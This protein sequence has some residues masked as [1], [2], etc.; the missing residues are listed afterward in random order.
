MFS[1]KYNF[2]YKKMNEFKTIKEWEKETHQK[3]HKGIRGMFSSLMFGCYQNRYEFYYKY[4]D[5]LE[6]DAYIW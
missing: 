5:C 3:A 6:K 1:G 4:K 2:N